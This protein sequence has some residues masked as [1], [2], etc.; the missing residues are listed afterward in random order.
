MK[1]LLEHLKNYTKEKITAYLF[2]IV[3]FGMLFGMMTGGLK[4]AGTFLY[5]YR[6]TVAPGT[7]VV[8]RLSGAIKSAEYAVSEGCF[9]R[10]HY[11]E[12]YGLAM[13]G[14]NKHSV[15]DF[16]YGSIY[17]TRDNQITFAV[18]EKWVDDAA[19]Q[20]ELLCSALRQEKIDFLYVQ[21]PFKIAPTEYGGQRE[22]PPYVHD[23]S[24]ENA[25][26][27]CRQICGA[28][29]DCFDLRKPFWES[30]RSQNEL[31]F[32][33]DHHWTIG[34]AFMATGMICDFIN[35]KYDLG[36]E[37]IYQEENFKKTLYPDYFIGSM[38][39]RV[40]R[41]YGGIDDFTL[42]TPDFDTNITL[43]EIAGVNDTVTEGTFE[44]AV[45]DWKYMEDEDPTSN[46]Y[47]VY[48]G[49][50][51]ELKFINHKI[52]NGK[53]I[54]IIKDSFGIPI[55]SFLSLGVSEVRAIDLRLFSKDVVAYAKKYDPD[56]VILMYNADSF[57]EQQFNFHFPEN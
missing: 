10:Q 20:T 25:D 50:C 39:R 5:N 12:A 41:I 26:E 9:L 48:H 31:F 21:L 35:E 29:V 14:L 27:F 42:Y 24:N 8:E 19:Y 3:I 53:K 37:N 6:T 54:L 2:L 23:Y 4:V 46:R 34:A 22:L 30:G 17:K 15:T 56:L 36:I 13:K 1:K 47:A 49:D 51:E 18:P 38:G 52:D 7:P 16:N 57:S 28:G 43:H 44:E 55:Y 33:T 11:V 45:L 40:G 32:D